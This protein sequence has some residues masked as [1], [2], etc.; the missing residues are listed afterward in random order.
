LHRLLDLGIFFL[1]AGTDRI[2]S[3]PTV[4][5][6]AELTKRAAAAAE[7]KA[8]SAEQ[9]LPIPIG[10]SRFGLFSLAAA[11]AVLS[12]WPCVLLG[13]VDL[14]RCHLGFDVVL[15]PFAISPGLQAPVL[16]F[17]CQR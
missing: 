12:C 13:T 17:R 3:C 10:I 2:V 7:S 16:R 9:Q 14:S 15:A 8:P 4:C 6:A 11:G 1:V 5:S